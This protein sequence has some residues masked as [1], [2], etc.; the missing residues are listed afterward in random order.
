MG[1]TNSTKNDDGHKLASRVGHKLCS[2]TSSQPENLVHY[3]LFNNK[4]FSTTNFSRR[5]KFLR[6]ELLSNSNSCQPQTRIS[7][8][9]RTYSDCKLLT[10]A[11]IIRLETRISRPSQNISRP[12]KWFDYKLS[13]NSRLASV[14]KLF[15]AYKLSTGTFPPLKKLIVVKLFIKI[16]SCCLDETFTRINFATTLSNSARRKV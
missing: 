1:E 13:S 15:L 11:K 6:F 16:S 10:T 9:T 4:L 14:A 7:R 2:V 12:Q 5:Y 3:K 8:P